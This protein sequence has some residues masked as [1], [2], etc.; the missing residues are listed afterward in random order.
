MNILVSVTGRTAAWCPPAGF[1]DELSRRFPQHAFLRAD[2]PDRQRRLLPVADVAMTATI[3]RDLFPSLSRLR[4]IQAPASGVAQLLFP[5]LVVSPVVVTSARGLR[6]RAIAEHV[7]AVTLVLAR[8]IDR[9]IYAQQARRWEQDAIDDGTVITLGGR[10]LCVVGLGAVGGQVAGLASAFGLTVT[11]VRRRSDLPPPDGVAMVVP[12]PRLREALADA[13]VIVLAAPL[14]PETRGLISAREIDAMK[15]GAM[16]VNV[17][18]GELIDESAL[19]AALR[20]H[21]LRGAALDVFTLEPL[22]RNSAYWDL[23]NVLVTPHTA[24]AIEDYWSALAALFA[25]NLARFDACRPLHN[26]VD[27]HAGY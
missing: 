8:R 21:H 3:D 27:K 24:G 5:E 4:W 17:G 19:A 25:D 13:D 16:L 23:P 20:R 6:A 22:G 26:E 11:G 7:L 15:R 2:D 9:A 10:R 14:T 18:R 12:A 1:V